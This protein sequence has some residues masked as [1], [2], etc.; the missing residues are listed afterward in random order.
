[1]SRTCSLQ[2]EVSV[3]PCTSNSIPQWPEHITQKPETGSD[4]LIS[5]LLTVFKPTN[6]SPEEQQQILPWGDS[7]VDEALS[8]FRQWSNPACAHVIKGMAE[9]QGGMIQHKALQFLLML[10]LFDPSDRRTMCDNY[11]QIFFT[12]TPQTTSFVK[13]SFAD[14]CV[15]LYLHRC[16]RIPLPGG[17][18]AIMHQ[19]EPCPKSRYKR[20]MPCSAADDDVC[21]A[22]PMI[23]CLNIIDRPFH[24]NNDD[25][26]I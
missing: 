1:M 12:D 16:R 7:E 11:H 21:A 22:A 6:A 19:L 2:F 23:P 17:R 25:T 9:I 13:A 10:A 4:E 14:S 5:T 20:E 3:W 18:I 15:R 24:I 26:G 8:H